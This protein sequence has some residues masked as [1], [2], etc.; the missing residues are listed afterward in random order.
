MENRKEEYYTIN[1]L[2]KLVYW[3]YR[4]LLRNWLFILIS[5]LGGGIIG[6]I[7]FYVQSPKYEAVSTFILEEKQSGMGGLSS[8][9]SQFGLDIGGITGGGSL[10]A[11]DNILDILLSKK[12]VQEVL[13]TR[14]KQSEKD[15]TSL[16]NI[17]LDFSGLRKKWINDTSLSTI[18]IDKSFDKL[19]S[20][21][22]SVLNIVY[23]KIVKNHLSVERA[24]KKGSIIIV[25]VTSKN[26][27]FSKELNERIIRSSAEL[28]YTI[29]TG[30]TEA[31]IQKLQRKSDSLLSLLNNKSFV[32][33]GV[34]PLDANP[35][36]KTT[37]V[38]TEIANRDKTVIA[39]L[40]A[41]VTKNLETSKVLLS[42]QSPVIQIL[43]RPGE[44]L[45]DNK[46]KIS[47]LLIIGILVGFVFGATLIFLK[48]LLYK[49]EG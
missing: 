40:Y 4:T 1:D 2:N 33:A 10:F 41:E 47:T 31:N 26:K 9:A 15:S 24:N 37:L 23:D 46:K 18:N 14:V 5:G 12:I 7:S 29:K 36:L 19:N 25:T 8:I 21:E 34:A 38:P 43:D 45:F 13:L 27:L 16:A 3:I 28:Y 35:G 49:H 44:S 39:T 11:G 30:I 17:Y 6:L 48:Q 42:Q 32:A 22:D 20:V